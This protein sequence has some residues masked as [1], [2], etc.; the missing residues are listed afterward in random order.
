MTLALA[1]FVVV[2]FF[3]LS[4]TLTL[5]ENASADLEPTCC[6]QYICGPGCTLQSGKM[7]K[8]E[9][10]LWHCVAVHAGDRSGCWLYDCNCF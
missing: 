6:Y 2:F 9:E 3:A 8:D 7:V 1:T 10:L 4:I 5:A